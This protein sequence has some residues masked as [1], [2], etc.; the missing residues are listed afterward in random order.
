M[1]Q[2]RAEGLDGEGE[3]LM[4]EPDAPAGR[5][6]RIAQQRCGRRRAVD[7]RAALLDLE[8]EARRQLGEERVE[9]EDLAG[10]ALARAGHAGQ[11][12]AVQHGGDGQGDARRGGGMALD[13]IRQP[14]QHDPAHHPLG[15]G[16]A[17]GG[18]GGKGLEPGMA[19]A[20]LQGQPPAR[21]LAHGRGDA[22]DDEIGI[23][24]D[25]LQEG[26]PALGDPLQRGLADPHAF[27]LPGDAAEAV[28][29]DVVARRQH[30]GHA[31]SPL[32]RFRSGGASSMP[33]RRPGQVLLCCPIACLAG[34]GG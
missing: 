4:G 14:R 9:G 1:L 29:I 33:C 26:L 5:Q 6:R 22:I 3:D 16:I 18:G 19:L 34:A 27:A 30:D 13:E 25:E 23:L 31:G 15:Q 2:R 32:C 21:Q 17:E 11:R 12:P 7:Q 24:V 20:L 8:I 28:E 10:S